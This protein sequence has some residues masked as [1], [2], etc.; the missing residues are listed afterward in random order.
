MQLFCNGIGKLAIF[1]M[2]KLSQMERKT[3]LISGATAGIGR[4][5][6]IRFGREHYNVIITGRRRELL[7][8]LEEELKRMGCRVVALH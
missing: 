4:A 1:E 3:V 8:E 2:S 6:A 7:A 5:T